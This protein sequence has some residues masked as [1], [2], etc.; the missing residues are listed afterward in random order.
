M[1]LNL[2]II[3]AFIM[4]MIIGGA[5][6]SFLEKMEERKRRKKTIDIWYRV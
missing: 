6:V 5:W 3:G 4:L 2:M 1:T